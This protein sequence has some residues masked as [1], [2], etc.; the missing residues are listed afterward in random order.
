[1]EELDRHYTWLEGSGGLEQWRLAAAGAAVTEALKGFMEGSLSALVNG[2]GSQWD[3]DVLKVV[4]R[5]TDPLSVARRWLTKLN[6]TK[7]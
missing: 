2:G 4:R 5:E 1:M 7:D 3:E 6:F